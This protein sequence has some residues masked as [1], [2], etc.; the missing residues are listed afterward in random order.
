MKT[1]KLDNETKIEPGF[2]VPD[3]YFDNFSVAMMQQL[4]QN[5]TP[6]ISIFQKKKT[7]IFSA[8]AA[9]FVIALMIPVLVQQEKTSTDEIGTAAIE[10]YITYESN[11]NQYDLIN[12]LNYDEIENMKTPIALGDEAIEEHFSTNTNLENLILE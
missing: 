7:I 2:K 4:E 6:V 11:V 3:H 9:L 8:V 1:F 12:G 5:E 10:N